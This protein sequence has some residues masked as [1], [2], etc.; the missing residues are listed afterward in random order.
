MDKDNFYAC[1]YC[2]HYDDNCKDYKHE[3]ICRKYDQH[4]N[5]AIIK[6]C[7]YFSKN[8]HELAKTRYEREHFVDDI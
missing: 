8:E 2:N 7:E 3:G 6:R 1:I 5:R 4:M